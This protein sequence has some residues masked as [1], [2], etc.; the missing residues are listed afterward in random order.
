MKSDKGEAEKSATK[1]A[2]AL[3]RLLKGKK[4][5]FRRQEKLAL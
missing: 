2:L 5:K 1:R 4:P 3:R